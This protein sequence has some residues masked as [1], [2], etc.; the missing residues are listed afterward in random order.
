MTYENQPKRGDNG[1][2]EKWRMLCMDQNMDSLPL[3][4]P[5]NG[6]TLPKSDNTY[7]VDDD[8]HQGETRKKA[9]I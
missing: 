1:N 3:S 5:P 7:I 8:D 4:N 6:T 2:R 9:Q